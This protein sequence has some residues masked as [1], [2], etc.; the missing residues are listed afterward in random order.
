MDEVQSVFEPQKVAVEYCDIIKQMS[1]G[2]QH[3]LFLTGKG[4]VLAV[5]QNEQF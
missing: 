3:T 1:L 4:D 2:Y 5:G